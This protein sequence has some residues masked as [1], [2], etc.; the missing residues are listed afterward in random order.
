VNDTL[1]TRPNI[2]DREARLFAQVPANRD[3]FL[4]AI[5]ERIPVERMQAV[6]LFPP[7]KQGVVETGVAVIAVVPEA[8][9]RSLRQEHERHEKHGL[10]LVEVS[11]GV[12]EEELSA[13]ELDEEAFDDLEL[14]ADEDLAE[15]DELEDVALHA[16]AVADGDL[17]DDFVP[18]DGDVVAPPPP[19]RPI[20]ITAS[21][22]HTL[23]GADRGKW[24]VEIIEQADAPLA[25]IEMVVAGVTQR[26]DEATEPERLDADAVRTAIAAGTWTAPAR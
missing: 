9:G 4:A 11:E 12:G 3:R 8:P 25:T 10:G 13:D 5:A 17:D 24:T 7:I 20:V 22:R 6:Y 16:V 15:D 2:S 19:P 21:Y 1:P 18:I 23:K 26:R 14:E